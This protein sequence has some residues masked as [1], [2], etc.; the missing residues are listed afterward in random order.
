MRTRFVIA[1][2]VVVLLVAAGIV[3]AV[4][5]TRDDES[6][7]VNAPRAQ[8]IVGTVEHGLLLVRDQQL[9]VR[10]MD[11]GI[12]Y[13]IARRPTADSYYAHPRWSPDGTRI[14]YVIAAQVAV[15][16]GDWGS[17]VAI[18]ATDGSDE[19]IVFKH[20]TMGTTIEGLAWAPDGRA[21]YLGVLESDIRDGRFYG[22]TLRLQRLDLDTG[23]RTTL[24]EGGAYP[25]VAPDGSRI[26]YLTYSGADGPGGLWTARPDGSDKRLILPLGDPIAGLRAPRFSPDGRVLAFGAVHVA[27]ANLPPVVCGTTSRLPWQ[28]RVASAHGPP[29]DIW[30]IDGDGN[31]LRRIADLREDDPTVA[32]S[33]DGSMLAVIGTCGLYELSS[34]GGGTQ[35]IGQ[36]ALLSQMDWR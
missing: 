2:V 25:T 12:E 14:A 9:L 22:S 20:E 3:A 34:G 6:R 16:G 18:S 32:W 36:G 11:S 28:P 27:D 23:R 5:L 21:L 17:D 24:A 10:D 7:F 35:R 33:P 4:V 8:P 31:N 19:R 29:V 13:E 30:A 15:S 26:A 1:G